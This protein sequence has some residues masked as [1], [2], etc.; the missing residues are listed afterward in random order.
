MARTRRIWLG[1]SLL[2]GALVLLAFAPGQ[3]SGTPATR[4]AGQRYR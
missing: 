1:R 4:C 3:A 2:A